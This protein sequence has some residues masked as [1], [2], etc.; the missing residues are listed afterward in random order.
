MISDMMLGKNLLR[1]T[2][3][4]VVDGRMQIVKRS[5]GVC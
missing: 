5:E 2:S 3:M 1:Y 4:S